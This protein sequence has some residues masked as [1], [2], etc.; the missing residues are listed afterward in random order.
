MSVNTSFTVHGFYGWLGQLLRIRFGAWMGTLKNP[1]KCLWRRRPT[2]GSTT[3]SSVRLHIYLLSHEVSLNATLS[4][5]STHTG[6]T[7]SLGIWSG[8]SKSYVKLG[9]VI[10]CNVRSWKRHGLWLSLCILKF[11][12]FQNM[13]KS[14]QVFHRACFITL[15]NPELQ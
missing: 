1:T 3:S 11:L 10:E 14:S 5:Q 6:V 13:Y 9:T 7:E 8:F 15:C 12:V 2:V 4:N